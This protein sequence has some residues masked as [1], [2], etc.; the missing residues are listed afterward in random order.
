MRISDWSSDVCSSDLTRI[1]RRPEHRMDQPDLLCRPAI[2]AEHQAVGRVLRLALEMIRP[3]PVLA[4]LHPEGLDGELHRA[5][6]RIVERRLVA[7][8]PPIFVGEPHRERKSV[9][10]G[11][12]VAGSVDTVGR[13]NIKKKK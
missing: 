12:S 13:R 4:L 11:K 6:P 7:R 10:K 8:A 3:R 5:A 2:T 9:V 1:I